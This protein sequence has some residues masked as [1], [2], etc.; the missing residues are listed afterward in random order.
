MLEKKS[1]IQAF[2]ALKTE[3]L[4]SRLKKLKT[5]KISSI[6]IDL[7]E[8]SIAFPSNS[9]IRR[10]PLNSIETLKKKL[11]NTSKKNDSIL[12]DS[13]QN[14]SLIEFKEEIN[15]DRVETSRNSISLT[16]NIMKRRV[17][18]CTEHPEKENLEAVSK[19]RSFFKNRKYKNKEK[20]DSF[21]FPQPLKT[22][23]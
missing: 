16:G 9:Q 5:Q 11:E 3:S 6:F 10:Q 21:N 14:L 19:S 2:Y 13:K 1:L 12:Q 18:T 8:K 17:L 20:N 4:I 15:Q 7:K 23:S 22:L